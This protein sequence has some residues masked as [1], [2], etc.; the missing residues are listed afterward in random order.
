MLTFSCCFLLLCEWTLLAEASL[1]LLLVLHFLVTAGG[2]TAR[3]LLGFF[4]RGG[5]IFM[6]MDFTFSKQNKQD[7]LLKKR[8]NGAIFN[9]ACNFF[10]TEQSYLPNISINWGRNKGK[11]VVSIN[12][13]LKEILLCIII[14]ISIL[15]NFLY[16]K[17][18]PE[19]GQKSELC[20][21]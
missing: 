7:T 8:W 1:C 21:R 15:N 13:E 12:Q 3:N 17:S 20:H 11:C 2:D 9:P 14:F 5:M 18:C 10:S 19:C 4:K 16:Q 6:D